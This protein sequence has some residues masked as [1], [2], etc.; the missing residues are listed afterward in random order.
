MNAEDSLQRAAARL[1]EIEGEIKVLQEESREIETA[2]SVMRR[3]GARVLAAGDTP[4]ADI[5]LSKAGQVIALVEQIA[6][7]T[8]QGLSQ[9]EF[10]GLA[11]Q[12]IK[13][14]GRPLNRT[15]ILTRLD[16]M[17]KPLGG[18]DPSK[19][20]G[21][22]LWRARDKFTNIRG[23]GYWLKDSPY[24]AT[25]YIPELDDVIGV[26][27]EPKADDDDEEAVEAKI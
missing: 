3:F 25:H 27:S 23:M 20:V 10:E 8:Q 9:I 6:S 5:P 1:S 18:E 24:P 22:K 16:A 7:P 17:G 11:T 4:A 12:L 21:T 15:E 19:N 2:I 13:D 14:A 26:G